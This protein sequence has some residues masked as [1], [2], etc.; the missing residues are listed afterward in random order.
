M[1]RLQTPSVVVQRAMNLVM[2][3]RDPSTAGKARLVRDLAVHREAIDS[4]LN[5]V[6]TIHFARFNL[7]EG[8]LLMISV[9][10]GGAESYIREFARTLGDVFDDIMSHVADWPPAPFSP[11]E[12]VSVRAHPDEFVEWVLDHDLLQLPR[13]PTELL[14][15]AGDAPDGA[16]P[17]AAVE[18]ALMR[19]LAR[20]RYVSLSTYRGYPGYSVAQIRDALGLGW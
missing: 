8:A 17:L 18:D 11:G 20:E 7:V 14:S 9:Y 5:A 10:D 15:G 12:R 1:A 16:D 6:G 3:L 13:D 19:T 2:P 4:G